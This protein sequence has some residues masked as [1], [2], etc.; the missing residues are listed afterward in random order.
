MDLLLALFCPTETLA[1]L[2]SCPPLSQQQKQHDDASCLRRG[3]FCC[4]L[5]RGFLLLSPAQL[6][7]VVSGAA[8]LFAVVTPKPVVLQL[9]GEPCCCGGGG[10]GEAW[11]TLHDKGTRRRGGGESCMQFCFWPLHWPPPCA[12][13]TRKIC[14]YTGFSGG[15]EGGCFFHFRYREGGPVQRRLSALFAAEVHLLR[16]PPFYSPSLYGLFCNP[17]FVRILVKSGE[18]SWSLSGRIQAEMCTL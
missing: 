11:C 14:P 10:G 8:P 12:D 7:A 15:R 13:N 18:G 16:P 5:R 1:S 17:S 9:V 6:F 4:C 2:A 3:L